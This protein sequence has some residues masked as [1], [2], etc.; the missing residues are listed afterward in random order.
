MAVKFS[1]KA[2][3]VLIIVMGV[4]VAGS[5]KLGMQQAATSAGEVWAGT[6]GGV[7]RIGY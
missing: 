3:A 1:Y 7:T 2:W 6:L 5:Y 4:V